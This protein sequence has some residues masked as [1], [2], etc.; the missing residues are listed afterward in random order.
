MG[1]PESW[2]V[3]LLA[4]E[5]GL[6]SPLLPAGLLHGSARC[7]SCP[8]GVLSRAGP[9]TCTEV[10][11]GALTSRDVGGGSRRRGERCVAGILHARPPLL[12]FCLLALRWDRECERKAPGELELGVPGLAEPPVLREGRG[13][14]AA[15]CSVAPGSWL[16]WYRQRVARASPLQ[17]GCPL[18]ARGSPCLL[19]PPWYSL[20]DGGSGASPVPTPVAMAPGRVD[21]TRRG[22]FALG[23]SWDGLAE[24]VRTWG[25]AARRVRGAAGRLGQGL[26]VGDS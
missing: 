16:A 11:H 12:A 1:V 8:R 15:G 7:S 22:R 9:G 3:A 25:W 24:Q 17:P 19:S 2:A 5:M 21:A 18:P 13:C 4:H 6:S 23:P 14:G 26:S 10:P 20:P